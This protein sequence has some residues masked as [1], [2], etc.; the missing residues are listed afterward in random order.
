M[1]RG[2]SRRHPICILLSAPGSGRV[3]FTPPRGSAA[4]PVLPSSL[5]LLVSSAN[6]DAVVETV[7]G[8]GSRYASARHQRRVEQLLGQLLVVILRQLARQL[9]QG[10]AVGGLD[11]TVG[12]ILAQPDVGAVTLAGLDR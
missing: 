6:A 9:R 4:F 12:M 5:S 8:L 2:L 1:L 11:Q 10:R 7:R 3:E